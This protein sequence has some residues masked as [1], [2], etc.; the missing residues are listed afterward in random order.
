[1]STGTRSQTK[2]SLADG[3]G[4]SPSSNSSTSSDESHDQ[5]PEEEEESTALK[6]RRTERAEVIVNT[7]P[8]SSSSSSSSSSHHADSSIHDDDISHT[9]DVTMDDTLDPASMSATADSLI[10]NFQPI[11]GKNNGITSSVHN[12]VRNHKRLC[13][14]FI[15][16]ISIHR[17]C[18]IWYL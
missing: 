8:L 18:H 13:H 11:T 9:T 14:L 10:I 2:R 3:F 6:K 16:R 15:I 1:M 4:T 5:S 7:L 17:I 12:K